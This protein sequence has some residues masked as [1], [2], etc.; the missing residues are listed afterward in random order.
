MRAAGSPLAA[1]RSAMDTG[2]VA[3]EDTAPKAAVV[4][5]CPGP[6]CTEFAMVV[7]SVLNTLMAVPLL[8]EMSEAHQL[9]GTE[10]S[11]SLPG[12]TVV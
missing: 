7:L 11:Q 3:E 12:S 5:T 10:C 2:P 4:G 8:A 1:G 6:G 9:M